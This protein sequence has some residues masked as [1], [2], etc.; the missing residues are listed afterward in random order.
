[1]SKLLSG[2]LLFLC[3]A[4]TPATASAH[5]FISDQAHEQGAVLHINPDDDPIAGQQANLF[6]DL[7]GIRPG[8][9]A[10][11]VTDAAGTA[12]NIPVQISGSSVSANYTF[13]AQGV[14]QLDLQAGTTAKTYNFS[15]AQR[16]S[17]GT[18]AG[19]LD[20]SEPLWADLLLY[21]GAVGIVLLAV[22][23]AGRWREIVKNS[24]LKH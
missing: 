5:V 18:A 22:V 6:F 2:V 17:R 1:M 10:L 9:A 8:E 24:V 3:L 23:A 4:L 13:P 19:P 21:G 7:Q 16:V 14:Y 15:Y 12:A 20:Q 11:T